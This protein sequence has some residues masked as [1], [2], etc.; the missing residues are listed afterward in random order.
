MTRIT[1]IIPARA[2]ENRFRMSISPEL[3]RGAAV[4]FQS[5]TLLTW[6]RNLLSKGKRTL[7]GRSRVQAPRLASIQP[8]WGGGRKKN[9]PRLACWIPG[10]ASPAENDET[11]CESKP[12]ESARKRT[13]Q[14]ARRKGNIQGGRVSLVKPASLVHAGDTCPALSSFERSLAWGK[15]WET[16]FGESYKDSLYCKP[17]PNTANTSVTNTKVSLSVVCLLSIFS[18]ERSGTA[19]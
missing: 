8:A 3:Q 5:A 11:R 17:Q 15:V 16:E 9:G 1:P 18:M 4:P 19:L 7:P 6:T 10:S 12:R 2:Q 14:K 13:Q